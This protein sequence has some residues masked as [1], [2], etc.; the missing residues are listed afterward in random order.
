[1][2]VLDTLS[3]DDRLLLYKLWCKVDADLL[4]TK[5]LHAVLANN[6]Q[7]LEV[8]CQLAGQEAFDSQ[9]SELWIIFVAFIK[10]SE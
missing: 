8:F 6:P 7:L 2:V 1:M 10:R 4:A 3:A 9:T 5:I